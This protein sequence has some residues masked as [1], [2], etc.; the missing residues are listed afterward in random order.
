MAD[1]QPKFNRD[2]IAN[3]LI[4]AIGVCLV[5]ATLVSSAAVFL[6][7]LQEANMLRDKKKNILLAA[8]LMEK[9][10][11][12]NAVFEKRIIDQIIDLDTGEVVTSDYP[13]PGEYDPIL[14]AESNDD[15]ESEPLD[16]DPATIKRRE[17][18]AHVYVVKTSDTDPT[19]LL[20]VFPVRGKGLWS[21]LKGFIALDTDLNTIEGITFYEHKETPGLGGEVDN[22]VWKEHWVGKE[23]FNPQGQVAI[24]LVK[25]NWESSPYTVDALSGATITSRGVERMLDFWMGDTGFGPYLTRLRDEKPATGDVAV[26]GGN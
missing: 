5:C 17:H 11:D 22:P 16:E 23:L 1:N 3:T 21:I 7:G 12:I 10:T 19:P 24:R 14:L 8:G 26:A 6:K 9:N 15:E 25:A 2:S 20:Y 4:V 13:S 18:R